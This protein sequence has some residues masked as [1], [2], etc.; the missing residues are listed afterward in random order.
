ML[1]LC[2]AKGLEMGFHTVESVGYNMCNFYCIN[3]SKGP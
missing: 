2:P 3:M 1:S